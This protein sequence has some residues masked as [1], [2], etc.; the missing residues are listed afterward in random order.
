MTPEQQQREIIL[1]LVGYLTAATEWGRTEE[2][3]DDDSSDAQAVAVGELLNEVM[4]K[5]TVPADMPPEEIGATVSRE[6][7]DFMARFITGVGYIFSELA[8]IHD[9]GRTDITSA[10]LLRTIALRMEAS[11]GE[12]G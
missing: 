2:A 7:G 6:L 8:D 12:E 11:R 1:R 4:P 10:D 3:A 5:V 9:S